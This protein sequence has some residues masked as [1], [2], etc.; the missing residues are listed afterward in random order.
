MRRRFALWSL[1]LILSCCGAVGAPAQSW[2]LVPMDLTQAN[3]LKAYGLAFQVLTGGDNVNW[4]LNYRGGS[5]LMRATA[6]TTLSAR[7]RGVSFEAIGDD[8][9]AVIRAT[10]A[11]GNM[12]E[13]L[14]EKPPRIA[15]YAPP[16]FQPWDDAVTLALTYAEIPFEQIFDRDVLAGRLGDY[17]WLHLHHE[18]FT[19]QFGKFY[20]AFRM[21]PWYMEQQAMMEEMAQSLGFDAV[22]KLKHA[23]VLKVRDYVENGGFLFA[24]CS[25]T[26]T[27]DLGL[28][29]LGT[30]IVPSVVDGTPL[31][32]ARESKRD[33]GRTL[34]F[35]DFTLINDPLVY[36][37]STIDTS[38]Y[39]RLR[40]PVGDYFTLFGFSAK[41]DPVPTMLTQCH[42]NVINGF[43]GQTTGF[44]K[45]NLK[46][47]VV[48]L[49]QVEGTEEVRYIH[50]KLGLGTFTF[51]GGHDPEDYQHAVG[52]P[53]T[54]LDLYRTS[55]GYRLI[56]NNVLFPAA[57]K[58]PQKT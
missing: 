37:F 57:R 27:F 47:H 49:A 11:S 38:D 4:L 18:D 2:L 31:D 36:E 53:P 34:A 1:V 32:P 14:L 13:I 28:A 9:V 8:E 54:D 24:M 26:D 16:N 43:M 33:D 42:V 5:F 17:D 55:P 48:I 20:A 15:V 7:L 41:H 10:I 19:G 35:R 25:A 40:G 22:W 21:A 44:R 52:D 58:K 6:G 56:L 30:D 51:L 29:Y 50:G 45:D 23:V 3:H 46:R 12:E 39:A